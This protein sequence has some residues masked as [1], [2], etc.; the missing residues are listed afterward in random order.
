MPIWLFPIDQRQTK[1]N[2][3]KLQ[4]I[5]P[6]GLYY[7]WTNS[8]MYNWIKPPKLYHQILT[9]LLSKTVMCVPNLDKNIKKLTVTCD[10]CVCVIQTLISVVWPNHEVVALQPRSGNNT[11]LG[12]VTYCYLPILVYE[13]VA[14]Q[15]RSGNTTALG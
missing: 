14:L 1:P 5:K 9:T 11:A 4:G 7:P 6:M 12:Y 10:V 2:P 3:K 8:Y 13:V 15:P